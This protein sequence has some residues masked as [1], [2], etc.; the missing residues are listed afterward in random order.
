[1]GSAHF[2]VAA[3]D[4]IERALTQYLSKRPLPGVRAELV[5]LRESAEEALG[6]LKEQVEI[7][8]TQLLR[9]LIARR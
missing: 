5:R 4:H 1:M 6:S 9:R 8:D 3:V 2:L 7:E